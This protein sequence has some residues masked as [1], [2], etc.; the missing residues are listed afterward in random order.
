MLRMTQNQSL[1]SF[2]RCEFARVSVECSHSNASSCSL[3]LW[4]KVKNA[5]TGKEC[6]VEHFSRI[7]RIN[8]CGTVFPPV[9][10]GQP[11]FP[12][13]Y[14]ALSRPT[15]FFPQRKTLLNSFWGIENHFALELKT[16]KILKE[17]FFLLLL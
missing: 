2:K 8:Q 9:L 16:V 3:S 5:S 15:H 4:V 17:S 10:F 13:P 14:G 11:K 6:P 12:L 7:Q 1:L